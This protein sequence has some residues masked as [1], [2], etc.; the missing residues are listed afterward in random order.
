M[1]LSAQEFVRALKLQS[2]PQT[3]LELARKTWDDS[4]FLVPNKEE[5]IVEWILTRLLKEKDATRQVQACDLFLHPRTFQLTH[6]TTVQDF[7]SVAGSARLALAKR[8]TPSFVQ[9]DIHLTHVPATTHMASTP[10]QSHPNRPHSRSLSRPRES[11]LLF[12]PS[13]HRLPVPLCPLATRSPQIQ[14][15]HS[16][17]L[18]HCRHR[19]FS[20]PEGRAASPN[21]SRLGFTHDRPRGGVLPIV[22]GK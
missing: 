12:R 2:D 14:H 22:A 7:E 11:R 20:T 21:R 8:H 19:I 10:P 6:T 13:P 17:R 9:T 1:A 4:S 3:K 16:S 5:N 15:R 18:L